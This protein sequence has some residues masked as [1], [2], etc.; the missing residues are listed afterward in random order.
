MRFV[1]TR[2]AAAAA[3]APALPSLASQRRRGV[4]ALAHQSLLDCQMPFARDRKTK[5]VATMGP[6]CLP[7]LPQMLL[8]GINV[9]RIN[10]A[11]G[12]AE[13]YKGIVAAVRKAERE[14]RA[15]GAADRATM[16]EGLSGARRDLAAVAF[17]V[18]GPEIRIGRLARTCRSRRRATRRSRSRAATA[19]C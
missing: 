11:H 19:S 15:S 16:A 4:S 5:I 2:A 3:A 17:D 8:A 1:L 12:D 6:S 9:A 13:Q 7:I 14:V 18:K 10:C